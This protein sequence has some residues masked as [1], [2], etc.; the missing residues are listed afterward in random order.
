[1]NIELSMGTPSVL[2]NNIGGSCS[3]AELQAAFN[4][5]CESGA[6]CMAGFNCANQNGQMYLSGVTTCYDQ[7]LN[8]IMCPGA[9]LSSQGSQC[10]DS[11]VYIQ[12][13]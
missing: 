4:A 7:S 12:S 3:L 9:V 6:D 13:F 8:Q 1:M 5:T 2:S 10:T 11:T